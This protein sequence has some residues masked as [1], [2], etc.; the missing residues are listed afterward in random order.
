MTE[1]ADIK[2]DWYQE[3]IAERW[4]GGRKLVREDWPRAE[5]AK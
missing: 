1:H 3:A 2:Q 4:C 5:Q